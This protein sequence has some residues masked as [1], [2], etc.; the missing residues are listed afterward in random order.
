MKHLISV[1]ILL[2][3]VFDPVSVLSQDL[4]AERIRANNELGKNLVISDGGLGARTLKDL[5]ESSSVIVRGRYGGVVAT[6]IQFPHGQ[7]P[8]SIP[9]GERTREMAERG[10][11]PHKTI[12]I[13]IDEI[14]KGNEIL[15]NASTLRLGL[16]ESA[17]EE[18]ARA[19]PWIPEFREGEH[20]FFL[21]QEIGRAHV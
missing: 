19:A 15:V 2:L 11:L 4:A 9:G 10:G 12:E 5:V 8:Q 13:E 16:I 18:I 20:L 17:D 21:V 6:S 3:Q 7:E 14:I 1:A